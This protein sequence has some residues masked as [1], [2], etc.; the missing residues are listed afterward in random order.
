MAVAA[1]FDLSPPISQSNPTDLSS[2]T[3]FIEIILSI[4][5]SDPIVKAGALEVF[6]NAGDVPVLLLH[7]QAFR[8]FKS[9]WSSS[10]LGRVRPYIDHV[11]DLAVAFFGSRRVK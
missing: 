3:H 10:K 2:W 7:G 6:F 11:G 8:T 1:G 4:Y 5:A 9:T